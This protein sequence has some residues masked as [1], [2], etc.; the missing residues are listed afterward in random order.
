M[1]NPDELDVWELGKSDGHFELA[2]DVRSKICSGWTTDQ[3]LEYLNKE[4]LE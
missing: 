2:W 3:L 1:L 4:Y